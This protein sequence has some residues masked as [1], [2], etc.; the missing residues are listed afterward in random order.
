M[1]VCV[2]QTICR[3]YAY[4]CIFLTSA[5][6]FLQHLV[7]NFD[8]IWLLMIIIDWCPSSVKQTMSHIVDSCHLTQFNGGLSQ[9]HFADDEAVAWL[10]SYVFWCT[11]KENYSDYYACYYCYCCSYC[12]CLRT[13]NDFFTTVMIRLGPT[14]LLMPLYN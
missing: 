3:C 10:T 6:Y 11:C 5:S 1:H 4:L 8:G 13:V 14:G 2:S 7:I 9:L 12:C